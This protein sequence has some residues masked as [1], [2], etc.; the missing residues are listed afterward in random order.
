MALVCITLLMQN[1]I[2][3][4]G[5]PEFVKEEVRHFYPLLSG[6]PIEE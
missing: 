6:K 3:F 2:T 4:D 5:V 1:A